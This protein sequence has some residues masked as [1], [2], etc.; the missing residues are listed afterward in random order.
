MTSVYGVTGFGARKQIGLKIGI[1]YKF[2]LRSAH[3]IVFFSPLPF[4]LLLCFLSFT[5]MV[6]I[7]V[8]YLS[9]TVSLF[10]LQ[11]P[12]L[13][14][15]STTSSSHFP[16]YDLLIS[17]P[18]LQPLHLTSSLYNLLIS[19][20]L[21]NLLIS[22]PSLQPPHLTSSLQPPHL[23]PFSTTSSSYFPLYNFLIS[24][25]SLQPPHLTSLSTASSS[26]SPLYNLLISLPS[27]QPPHLTSHLY[28]LF[29]SPLST[30]PGGRLNNLEGFPAYQVSEARAYLAH[31]TF[32]S[33]TGLF[34]SSNQIQV[35][36]FF[37]LFLFFF[38]FSFFWFF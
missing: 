1:Q 23:T 14:P 17:L 25:L 21:Y 33:L 19:L 34:T 15:L 36:F 27:L 12:H 7:V 35:R 2:F 28:N 37:K 29:I 26:H 8:F 6:F 11:P 4:E 5:M 18:S 38:L 20:P 10:S 3:L 30:T 16:L 24:L 9:R 31:L 32:T 13:T 22:L